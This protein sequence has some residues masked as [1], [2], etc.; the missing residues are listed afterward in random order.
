[1]VEGDE[2]KSITI[3]V[4][5]WGGLVSLGEEEKKWWWDGDSEPL[6]GGSEGWQMRKVTDNSMG[7]LSSF[8][9][10]ECKPFIWVILCSLKN[11]YELNSPY[12]KVWKIV[13]FC[14]NGDLLKPVFSDWCSSNMQML[15]CPHLLKMRCARS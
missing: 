8:F 6:G 14:D 10:S 11:I 12:L 2:N 9:M 3:K 7:F 1:M 4:D 13:L 5:L 15:V